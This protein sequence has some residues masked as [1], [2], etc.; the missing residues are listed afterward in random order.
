[1]VED[2]AA[3]AIFHEPL[4][5]YTRGLIAC[6]PNIDLDQEKLTTMDGSPPGL[7]DPPKG[8]AFAPRCPLAIEKC[9]REQPPFVEHR[10]GHK[11]ACWRIE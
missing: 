10:P 1:M 6:V 3:E 9:R 7:V 4:H 11:A 2:A 5:P 8:C